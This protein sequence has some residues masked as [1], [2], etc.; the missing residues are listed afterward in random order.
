LE[1]IRR[2]DIL[3]FKKGDDLFSN[4]I[5]WMTN[6]LYCHV[7][8]CISGEMNL[9]IEASLSGVRSIDIKRIK[10]GYDVYRIREDIA[11][12]VNETIAYLLNKLHKKYDIMGLLFLGIIKL[13]VKIGFPLKNYSNKWQREK[14]YFCSELCYQAFLEGGGI[15]IVPHVDGASITSPQDIV[16]SNMLKLIN[17]RRKKKYE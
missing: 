16:E 15:D 12:D 17:L 1:T 4:I 10:T 6:S 5:S 9:G 8:I 13:L 2:G 11:Y 14:D 7:A 3:L